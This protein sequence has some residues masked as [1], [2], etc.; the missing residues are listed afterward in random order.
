MNPDKKKHLIKALDLVVEIAKGFCPT[1]R[2]GGVDNTCGSSG[3]GKT[4]KKLVVASLKAMP[5]GSKKKGFNSNFEGLGADAGK[6]AKSSMDKF[7]KLGYKEDKGVAETSKN[8][9]GNTVTSRTFGHK[10]GH[11]IHTYKTVS[12]KKK[13]KAH[14]VKPGDFINDVPVFDTI[15]RGFDGHYIPMDNG[16]RHKVDSPSASVTTQDPTSYEIN[17]YTKKP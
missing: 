4:G 2:G 15:R 14:E 16:T 7:K 1:G 12:P 6:A 8:R 10:E 5:A 9:A 11:T 3:G 17:L 13:R